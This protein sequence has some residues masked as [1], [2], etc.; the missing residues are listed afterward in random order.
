MTDSCFST[1]L[2]NEILYAAGLRLTDAH[3]ATC[4]NRHRARGTKFQN[5][6]NVPSAGSHVSW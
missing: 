3:M 6:G 1:R 5:M 4:N 2:R